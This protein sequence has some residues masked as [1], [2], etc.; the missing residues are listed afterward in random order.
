MI[1]VGQI[2]VNYLRYGDTAVIIDIRG[3]EVTYDYFDKRGE[4]VR[5]LTWGD[6]ERFEKELKSENFILINE[7]EEI[8]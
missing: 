5:R 3:G 4:E 7:D 2:W 1:A 8:I 6:C